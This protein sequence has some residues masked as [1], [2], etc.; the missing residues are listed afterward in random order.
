MHHFIKM[1]EV[2]FFERFAFFHKSASSPLLNCLSVIGHNYPRDELLVF[3]SHRVSDIYAVER[4]DLGQGQT[5]HF[6]GQSRVFQG[7]SILFLKMFLTCNF[8]LIQEIIRFWMKNT[9]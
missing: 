1:D 7:Q 3:V 8:M 4:R 5:P 2:S 6:Q 9:E